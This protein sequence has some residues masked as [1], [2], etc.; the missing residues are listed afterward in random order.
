[1]RDCTDMGSPETN[2]SQM[3][4]F[5]K[6][7]VRHQDAAASYIRLFVS[8]PAHAEDVLQEVAYSAAGSFERYDPDRPFTGWLITIAKQRIVDHYRREKKRMM[9]LS[10][11]AMDCLA[12]ASAEIASPGFS[13]E[14]LKALNICI[15]KLNARQQEVLAF[16]YSQAQSPNDIAEK[17][18]S[19]TSAVNALLYRI[20]KLLHHCIED[21]I[22][23]TQV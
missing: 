12:Q 8:D 4:R 22:E 11:E 13:E 7:W 3:Q 2:N 21:R 9:L 23:A 19:S 1:M 17:L 5:A 20:R 14:R 16:R 15:A 6:L 18:G 10:G